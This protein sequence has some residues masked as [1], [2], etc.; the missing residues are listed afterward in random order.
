MIQS[1][2]QA[3]QAEIAALRSRLEELGIAFSE[4]TPR[5]RPAILHKMWEVSGHIAEVNE[6]YREYVNSQVQASRSRD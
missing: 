2:H 3:L 6:R 1:D 5:V 4:A